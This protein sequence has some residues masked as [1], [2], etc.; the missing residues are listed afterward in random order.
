MDEVG[1]TKE[2]IRNYSRRMNLPTADKPAYACLASRFPYGEKIT[3]EK[4][5]R[6]DQAEKN[7]RETGF[8]LFRVRSHE[9]IARLEFSNTEIEKAWRMR[10]ELGEICK[11]AGF[12]YVAIDIYGYRTGAMNEVLNKEDKENILNGK[13]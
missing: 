4:L 7:L 6:V 1:L 11:K 9:N 3:T 2:E 10:K 12:T 8:H 5:N 13:S